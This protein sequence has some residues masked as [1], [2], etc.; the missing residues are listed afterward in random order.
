MG[1]G[2]GRAATN[3][4]I[5]ENTNEERF[6]SLSTVSSPMS[7]S[8]ATIFTRVEK[9]EE[10]VK[11]EKDLKDRRRRKDSGDLME[12]AS[13]EFEWI[14]NVILK[15][16]DGFSGCCCVW[17]P[18]DKEIVFGGYTS[19]LFYNTK[20]E[21]K[22][23]V[24]YKPQLGEGEIRSVHWIH[25]NPNVLLIGMTKGLLGR[26]DIAKSREECSVF[27]LVPSGK[28]VEKIQF[29]QKGKYF[30]ALC[31]D[32]LFVCKG[33]ELAED[34]LLQI[35]KE[36]NQEFLVDFVWFNDNTNRILITKFSKKDRYFTMRIPEGLEE[37]EEEKTD[38]PPENQP[39]V[40]VAGASLLS[41]YVLLYKSGQI[42]TLEL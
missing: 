14:P 13:P 20:E 5:W 41:R 33:S 31:G 28:T 30:I 36:I 12:E 1:M 9:K 21:T 2:G 10:D 11:M 29:A 22:Q 39:I 7:N 38:F 19:L 27:T 26:I 25:L 4:N 3:V 6:V 18:D 16:N 35:L 8:T 34:G 42:V 37:K 32:S 15:E 24:D 40:G 23:C 17:S